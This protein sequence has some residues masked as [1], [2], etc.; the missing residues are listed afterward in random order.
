MW[1]AEFTLDTASIVV[2]SPSVRYGER[3]AALWQ[4]LFAVNVREVRHAS[5]LASFR[6]YETPEQ[7]QPPPPTRTV[8]QRVPGLSIWTTANGFLLRSAHTWLAVDVAASC[9]YG[10]LT[11]EFWHTPQLIQR[12]FFLLS[13]TML[14]RRHGYYGLHANGLVGGGRGYMIVGASGSGKTTLTLSLV[15]AGW[16]YV[17]DDALLLKDEPAA[18]VGLALRRSFACT[19]QTLAHFPEL[20]AAAGD[21]A[22]GCKGAVAL[23]GLFPESFIPRC[24]PAVLLFP[25]IAGG[26]QSLLEPLAP[27]QAVLALLP[28]SAG[29]FTDHASSRQQLATLV[30]VAHQASSYTLLLGDDVFDEPGALV[31]LL[32]TASYQG[33]P[34]DG[35][36]RRRTDQSLQP[37]LPSLL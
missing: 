11:P 13:L 36:H 3:L 27:T 25:R 10:V 16:Q 29:M 33:D 24:T 4:A 7:A 30:R 31:N 5:P 35:A 17:A 18:V 19:A 2:T 37:Q 23:D 14:L 34:T 20:A 12:D 26:A 28:Q 9:A 8:V 1:Q 32:S 6:L 15:R 22:P 21:I